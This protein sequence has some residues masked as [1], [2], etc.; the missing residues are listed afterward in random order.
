MHKIFFKII[1]RID[2]DI[3]NIKYSS[4]K[5][6]KFHTMCTG[7]SLH[8]SFMFSLKFWLN[9][10]LVIKGVFNWVETSSKL[11]Y[12][13]WLSEPTLNTDDNINVYRRFGITLSYLFWGQIS[14]NSNYRKMFE[15]LVKFILMKISINLSNM[16][17]YAQP[18][19]NLLLRPLK[20]GYFRVALTL[21][22][23]F[24]ATKS[25]LKIDFIF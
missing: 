16:E 1:N 17:V 6:K 14:N 8:S 9:A 23:I 22:R 20:S 25:Y 3:K 19:Q 15:Y 10:K 18:I 13:K 11:D 4:N 7:F 24:S 12:T 2:F 21:R 5:F